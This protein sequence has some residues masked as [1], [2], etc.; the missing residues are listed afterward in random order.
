[1]PSDSGLEIISRQLFGVD[2]KAA[3]YAIIDGAS[4]EELLK[5][6]EDNIRKA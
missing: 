6:I 5:A 3:T 2:E 4:V 1:M